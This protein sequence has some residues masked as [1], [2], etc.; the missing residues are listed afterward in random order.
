MRA[1]RRRLVLAGLGST[2]LSSAAHALGSGLARPGV[3]GSVPQD[4]TGVT[5]DNLTWTVTGSVV[6]VGNVVVTLNPASPAASGGTV[7]LGGADQALFQLTNGGNFPCAYQAKAATTVGTKDLSFS[8]A[9]PSY[10]STPKSSGTLHPVGS[11]PGIPVADVIVSNFGGGTMAAGTPVRFAHVFGDGDL[12]GGQTLAIVDGASNPVPFTLARQSTGVNGGMI[13]VDIL[14]K[15]ARSIAAAGTDT[16]TITSTAGP[17]NNTMPGGK[18][19]ANIVTD[20]TTNFSNIKVKLSGMTFAGATQGSGNWQAD[21]N[22]GFA[23]GATPA[24]GG[25]YR[26]VATGPTAAD[27]VVYY[28]MKDLVGGAQHPTLWAAFYITAFLNTSTGAVTHLCWRAW[29]NQG[30]DNASSKVYRCQISILLNNTVV[31]GW[32]GNTGDGRTADFASS[33][34]SANAISIPGNKFAPGQLVRFTTTGTLPTG[35]AINTDYY[36]CP[37]T[38]SG[39]TTVYFYTQAT[40]LNNFVSG[41]SRPAGS[42]SPPSGFIALTN[43]GSGTHTV[44]GYTQFAFY[45]MNCLADVDGLWDWHTTNTGVLATSPTLYPAQDSGFYRKTKKIFPIQLGISMADP[46]DTTPSMWSPMTLSGISGAPNVGGAH[47]EYGA[48]MNEY[49]CRRLNY[50]AE[51][52]YAQTLRAGTL[53]SGIWPY[54]IFDHSN[55]RIPA[56]NGTPRGPYTGLNQ[57]PNADVFSLNGVPPAPAGTSDITLTTQTS[58]WW[59]F[60]YV[61]YVTEGGQDILDLI[62][63]QANAMGLHSVKDAG[64]ASISRNQVTAAGTYWT[65]LQHAGTEPRQNAWQFQQIT[66]GWTIVPG[67]GV[68]ASYPEKAYFADM[69]DD[70]A[71]FVAFCRSAS[72]FGAAFAALGGW[73]TETTGNGPQNVSN[74]AGPGLPNGETLTTTAFEQFYIASAWIWAYMRRPTSKMLVPATH[75]ATYVN[76]WWAANC[77]HFSNAYN[78]QVQEFPGWK[79]GLATNSNWI[80]LSSPNDRGIQQQA[81]DGYFFGEDGA[82]VYMMSDVNGNGS[83]YKI[84]PQNGDRILFW[85]GY[86]VIVGANGWTLPPTGI[87]PYTWYYMHNVQTIPAGNNVLM[88]FTLSSTDPSDTPVTWTGSNAATTT[89][90]SGNINASVTAI[91]LGGAVSTGQSDW[92]ANI[93]KIGS[94]Y[95]CV[96]NASASSTLTASDNSGHSQMIIAGGGSLVNARGAFG[97]T[98][99][100]HSSGATV[101]VYKTS[102][103]AMIQVQGRV[104]GCPATTS[105]FGTGGTVPFGYITGWRQS[106]GVAAMAGLIG[107]TA[108]NNADA[109]FADYTL[110]DPGGPLAW[111]NQSASMLSVSPDL[112]F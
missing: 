87:P 30:L 25:Y 63:A 47:A 69:L 2:A 45:A 93:V 84:Q 104:T 100:S 60:S 105:R 66:D 77:P 50:M 103:N 86:D 4:I 27:F 3:S 40:F 56:L 89:T 49:A 55:Y 75:M 13:C 108:F 35:L 9:N 7:T 80:S 44:Q 96:V 6:T 14:A 68:E 24:A 70:S 39:S 10:T 29:V 36:A 43:S 33:A 22:A 34:I 82:T 81:I 8:Y 101:V 20:I 76:N 11:P 5:V 62:I 79:A 23:L 74:V 92:G 17:V 16:F 67:Q 65:V 110:A 95:L 97:S 54:F 85:D 109:L 52:G 88:T 48:P 78:H 1:I 41:S 61:C 111:A 99:A 53:V 91:P 90:L 71:D 102:C 64:Y 106:A 19:V 15:T 31:R 12:S 83:K 42:Y 28:P 98:A 112:T 21:S 46:V 107:A 94:E 59:T 26:C 73:H 58:H 57:I 32:G 37:T 38:T 18:T 72:G 51:R